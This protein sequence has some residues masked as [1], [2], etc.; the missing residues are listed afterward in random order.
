MN[1]KALNRVAN[2]VDVQKL[3]SVAQRVL[4]DPETREAL[5]QT[6][7]Q[8]R[9]VFDQLTAGGPK[10]GLTKLARKKKTQNELGAFVR[11][12]AGTVDTVKKPKRR[13]RKLF[14][15]VVGVVGVGALLAKRKNHTA[16]ADDLVQEPAGTPTVSV[17]GTPD[18]EQAATPPVQ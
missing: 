8:G 11:S 1:L 5:A 9:S 10:S 16:S 17:N 6:Y 3:T 2:D 4:R 12:L 15:G 14:L 7:A 13:L 18:R